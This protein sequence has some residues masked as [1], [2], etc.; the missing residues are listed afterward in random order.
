[1]SI[2]SKICKKLFNYLEKGMSDREIVL[3]DDQEEHLMDFINA[4]LVK[5]ETSHLRA[6]KML[7]MFCVGMPISGEC[8]DCDFYF[9]T[10]GETRENGC[11][12]KD[13]TRINMILQNDNMFLAN[14]D[15]KIDV[16]A[17]FDYK[18]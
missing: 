11:A 1:M 5:L 2:A 13:K 9:S 16:V 14:G 4:Q 17:P 7:G 6:V 8:R 12:F 15:L 18:Q 10:K 3:N